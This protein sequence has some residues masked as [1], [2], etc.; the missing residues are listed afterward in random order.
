MDDIS[1]KLAELLNDPDSLNRVREMAENI[2]GN[3]TAAPENQSPF[4]NNPASLFDG[5]DFDPVQIGKIMSIMSRL[6]AGKED[7]RSRL[8]LALKPHLS[9]P[10]QEKVDTAIK[11]LKIIDLL[12]YLKDSGMFDF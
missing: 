5:F 3:N 4:N 10:R 6:R 7:N 1:E 8:L 9:A 12:P 2:L 11:L